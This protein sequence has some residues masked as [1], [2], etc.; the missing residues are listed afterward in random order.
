MSNTIA[1]KP[2]G[3]VRSDAPGP[4]SGA[5]RYYFTPRFDFWDGEHEWVLFGDLPGVTADNLELHFDNGQLTV[6]GHVPS[7]YEGSRYL[8]REYGVADFYRTFTLGDEVDFDN[9]SAEMK[10]GVLTIRLP[11]SEAIKPRRIE[12]K[13]G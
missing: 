1:S 10:D 8:M 4:A 7:R 6:H 3:N 5:E 2:N 13:A 11:K 12:V 9:I